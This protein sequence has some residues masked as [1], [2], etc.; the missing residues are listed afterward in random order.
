[1][2]CGSQTIATQT[3]PPPT[4]L[5]QRFTQRAV[6]SSSNRVATLEQSF[7]AKGYSLSVARRLSRSLRP[8]SIILYQSRWKNF[9]N[10]CLNKNLSAMSTSRNHIL[11]YFIY[12]RDFKHLSAIKSHRAAI[13]VDPAMGWERR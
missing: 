11:E 9:R 6:H 12:L 2:F 10:W 13:F 4:A 8:S 3:R 1:M 7:R 5:R